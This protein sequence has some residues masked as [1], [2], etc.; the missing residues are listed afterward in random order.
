ME[1]DLSNKREELLL[2]QGARGALVLYLPYRQD[3]LRAVRGIPGREWDPVRRRWALPDR[4]ETIHALCRLFEG[5]RIRVQPSLLAR[6]PVLHQLCSEWDAWYVPCLEQMKRKGFSAK[7]CK[8]YLGH[9]ERC[10]R[11]IGKSSNELKPEDI[12]RYLVGLIDRE[13]SVSFVNQAISALRVCCDALGLRFGASVWTRPKRRRRLPDVMTRDEVLRLLKA[14]S[15]ERHR[16]ILTLIYSAGLRVGEAVRLRPADFD[17]ERGVIHIREGKGG[18]DRYTVLS[19]AVHRLLMPYLAAGDGGRSWLFPGA[20]P[21]HHLRERTIQLVFDKAKRAAS[22]RKPVTV[23]T[24]RHSFATHL[25]EDGTDLRC[26]QELL[27]HASVKTT[28]LY[29]HLGVQDIRRVRS[30]LDR[31]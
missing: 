14:I 16:L 3:L 11:S 26:I 9:M 20:D 25:L 28:Q 31:M 8:A 22:I 2:E 24:L 12:H 15:N 23:H 21:R 30:P 13:V 7:T 29:T 6:Y 19:A 4:E 17:S 10:V 27:G 18:K 5:C 1:R